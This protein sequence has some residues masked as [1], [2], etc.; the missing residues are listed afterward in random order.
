MF[1][2]YQF[3]DYSYNINVFTNSTIVFHSNKIYKII[4]IN[5]YILHDRIIL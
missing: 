5:I 4:N 1:I 2:Y 3:C